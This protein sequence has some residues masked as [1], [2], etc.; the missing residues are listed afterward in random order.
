MQVSSR[1]AVAVFDQV[2]LL[3]LGREIGLAGGSQDR[4]HVDP[5][6]VVPPAALPL[7]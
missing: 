1:P 7:Q 3:R 6:V 5:V 4:G 2:C